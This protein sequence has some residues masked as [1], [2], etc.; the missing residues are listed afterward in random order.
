MRPPLYL[1][2]CTSRKGETVRFEV[3]IQVTPREGIVDP[4][5]QTIGQALG[6]LGYAGVHHVKA[7]RLV[8]FELDADDAD[9][10][11][12]SVDRMCEELIANPVIE[13]YEVQIASP[14]T[15][16]P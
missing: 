2:R 16:S 13:R 4:E 12:S 6:N 3:E 11:R 1:Y 9:Q 15:A 14:E 8:H 7:G 10:A 5:G